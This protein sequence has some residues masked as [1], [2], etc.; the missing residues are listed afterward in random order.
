MEARIGL[1]EGRSHTLRL[2]H[3]QTEVVLQNDRAFITTDERLIEY[4]KTRTQFSVEVTKR[5]EVLPPIDPE[6]NEHKPA[7]PGEAR[8]RVPAK[9]SE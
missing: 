1:L 7:F 3:M 2:P 8:G 4:C 9:R 6:M 5:D